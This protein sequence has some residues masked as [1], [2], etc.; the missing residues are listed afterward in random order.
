[1]TH[2]IHYIH[3]V[4]NAAYIISAPVVKSGNNVFDNL[5]NIGCTNSVKLMEFIKP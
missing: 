4:A 1:M 5:Y 2:Y 3:D